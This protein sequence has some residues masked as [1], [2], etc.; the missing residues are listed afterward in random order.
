MTTYRPSAQVTL[1]LRV[2]EL[3]DVDPLVRQLRG[4]PTSGDP[5]TPPPPTVVPAT[6]DPAA[7]DAA[8]SV[9]NEEILFLETN[10]ER[11][12]DGDTSVDDLL[13]NLRAER[14]GLLAER[15]AGPDPERPPT[16]V[17]ADPDGRFIRNGIIPVE[18]EIERNGFRTADTANI[19]LNWKDV[20]FDPR[21]VRAA[22]VEVIVGVVPP[23]DFEAG[24]RGERD[25]SGQ[26]RS[27]IRQRPTGEVAGSAIR[28]A[29]WVDTWN[30]T[31]ANDK[32]DLVQIE[33]RDYTALFLDTPL[34]SSS[35][36]DLTLPIVDGVREFLDTYNTL[37]GFPVRYG[38][39]LNPDLW[40]SAVIPTP[41]DV[42]PDLLRSRS[43]SRA[44]S[45][46]R[47][48]QRMNLWDHLTDVCVPINLIPIVQDY[49]LWLCPPRTLT[50]GDGSP[51]PRRMVF[52]RNLSG[53]EF[54][55][56]L[57][58]VKVPTIEVRCFDPTVGRTRW[59][60]YPVRRGEPTHGVF[61]TTNPP[62]PLRPNETGVSGGNPENRI[63]T[64]IVRPMSDG[65]A[66]GRVA[67]GLYEQIGRQE[68]EGNFAT[69]D[70]SSWNSETDTPLNPDNA[71]LLKLASGESVE[72]LVAPRDPTRPE[73]VPNTAAALA[74]LSTAGR[75]DYL[76]SLGWEPDVAQRFAAWQE[77]A[78]FQTIFRVQNVNVA[79]SADEGVK[80]RADFVNYI[81]VRE[82]AAEGTPTVAAE[83]ASSPVGL[84][85]LDVTGT[86]YPDE[87][88]P[89]FLAEFGPGTD[90]PYTLLAR[91]ASARRR[92]MERQRA[93]GLTTDAAVAEAASE[94][95]RLA[96]QAR[97][98]SGVGLL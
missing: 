31:Y 30:V 77:G 20:P 94:E 76:V 66:L 92:Y 62:R 5:P 45:T 82:D 25:E 10:R 21:L 74:G 7:I 59:G 86:L 49:T 65:A 75:R 9:I 91:S 73:S 84:P 33:C 18:V 54:T 4:E 71:D 37:R 85:P 11:Y 51:P 60:R 36:V 43:G 39:P 72:L 90:D 80:L 17:S 55:R 95:R 57:G 3:T 32:A 53:L 12:A 89:E 23:D 47:G 15:L 98:G 22:G 61:G 40:A 93:D 88:S 2:D 68:I 83:T 69:S 87:P 42:L 63:Q 14:D 67:A 44:R 8:V 78:A 79:Y 50:S 41:G 64:F 70:V 27:V 19:V 46:R 56:K 16:L 52:G 81:V 97:L 28:F 13:A 26:L 96:E 34:A 24:I 58:G 1:Y 6:R 29:G 38:D 35:G 48:D